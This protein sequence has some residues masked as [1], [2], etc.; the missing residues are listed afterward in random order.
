MAVFFFFFLLQWR[1]NSFLR[2]SNFMHVYIEPMET[3][4]RWASVD[5]VSYNLMKTYIGHT[6]HREV[7]FLMHL[8]NSDLLLLLKKLLN[9]TKKAYNMIDIFLILVYHVNKL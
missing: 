5:D 9:F 6:V 7:G 1:L 2:I 4:R 8:S 3:F